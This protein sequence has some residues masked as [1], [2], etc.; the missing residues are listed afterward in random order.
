MTKDTLLLVG[1]L[2]NDLMRV[3]NCTFTGSQKTAS[4][5]AIEARRWALALEKRR[6]A[7]HIKNIAKEVTKNNLNSISQEMAET[8]LMYAILL[9]NYAVISMRDTL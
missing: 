1:S 6:V 5:F 4:R 3:A 7:P 8:Y 9:Q 2:S